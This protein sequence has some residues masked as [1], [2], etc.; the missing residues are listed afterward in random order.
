MTPALADRGD[1]QRGILGHFPLLLGHSF[2][3]GF[4]VIAAWSR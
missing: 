1:L 3:L 2:P 4:E